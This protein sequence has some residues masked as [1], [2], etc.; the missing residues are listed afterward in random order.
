MAF[1]GHWLQLILFTVDYKPFQILKCYFVLYCFTKYLS[2]L[3]FNVV[4]EMIEIR[5]TPP[6][7]LPPVHSKKKKKTTI[8]GA[9]FKY[10][11]EEAMATNIDLKQA[12]LLVSLRSWN[13]FMRGVTQIKC[14]NAEPRS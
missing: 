10:S 2:Y 1:E 13:G 9:M 7:T 5:L 11:C 12:R 4:P 8:A 3:F 6:L 14:F